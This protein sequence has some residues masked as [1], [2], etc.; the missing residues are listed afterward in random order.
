MNKSDYSC[1]TWLKLIWDY[2]V[3]IIG[4]ATLILAFARPESRACMILSSLAGVL[5]F[6]YVIFFILLCLCSRARFDW[7]L[8]NGNYIL[9]VIA[10]VIL[11]PFSLSILVSNSH[12]LS[13]D[14]VY[15]SNLY[16]QATAIDSLVVTNEDTLKVVIPL[17]GRDGSN[18]TYEISS[19]NLPKEVS[20]RQANPPL[21]W[22]VYYHFIDPGNQHMTASQDG[23]QWAAIIAILGVFLLNGLLVSS[24]IGWIDSRKVRWFK[25]DVRYKGLLHFKSHYVIIGA[26]DMVDGIVQQLLM[27]DKGVFG[28]FK[29]YI[30][31]QTSRDVE[32]FRRSLFSSLTISQQKRIIVYYGNRNSKV[33]IHDLCLKMAEEVYVL[34]EDARVDDIESYHDTINM[35]CLQLISDNIST[36][37]RFYKKG[38]VDKRLV[39]RVMFEYQTSFNVFKVT[40]INADKIKF[41]PFNYYEKWAQNVMICQEFDPNVI[42]E[43]KYLPLEGPEGIKTNDPAFVH[44]IIVGMSRMGVA[45]AIETAHL[46]HYPN[47]ES[48]G[49]R[50]KISFI[51]SNA[52]GE[53]DFFMSRFKEL[54]SLSHWRYGA[55]AV[56]GIEWTTEPAFTPRKHLGGD[57][58]DIEWEFI[59]GSVE[60]PAVQQYIDESSK[61][62]DA[63]LTI[64]IC[65]PE[66]SRAIATAAYLPDSVYQSNNTLQVL[67]YQRLNEELIRQISENNVR[68][69]KKIK[70]FGMAKGCY[71]SDLVEISEFMEKA[72]DDAYNEYNKTI[73]QERAKSIKET[74]KDPMKN[75]VKGKTNAARMWSNHYNIYS[76]WTKFRCVSTSDGHAFNPLKEEFG[77]TDSEMMVELGQMEHNRWILEQLLLRYRPLTEKEQDEAKVLTLNDSTD[78]KEWYKGKF[79]HLD[80]CSN[81][82]LD[83]IDYNISQLDKALIRVLPSAYRQFKERK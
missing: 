39:C 79:A 33:D 43:G 64:A 18:D 15:D 25:G 7:H 48:K 31:I 58:I 65:I 34:G 47:Y 81:K 73:R 8:V 14:L 10:I 30:L 68:Y 45:M 74:P 19:S 28:F 49:I 56:D 69:Q 17:Y 63:K 12:I 24:I 78:K 55:V 83:N 5:G 29:P 59:K 54:F 20:D 80:I 1:P 62:P 35:E 13:E 42:K 37:K 76:M 6:I 71:D 75:N 27:R 22:T 52:D 53:K 2:V 82:M 67:V 44:L 51:D 61:N 4:I 23:R 3:V 11:V 38:C 9:K 50:T 16:Q 36:Y 72:I 77:S 60:S 32:S 26:N 70:A 41:L 66:N 40:D 46:A 57:F 21:F